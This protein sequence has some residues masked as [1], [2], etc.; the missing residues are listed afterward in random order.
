MYRGECNLSLSLVP[1]YL[2][3][4]PKWHDSLTLSLSYPRQRLY[5]AQ[6]Y[7]KVAELQEGSGDNDDST[8]KIDVKSRI[9]KA[10][11]ALKRAGKKDLYA[12]LGVSQGADQGDIKK[13]YK[14]AALKYVTPPFLPFL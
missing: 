3:F 7:E 8:A 14:K 9:K 1:R 11:V 5:Y 10:K 2:Y 6:D 4:L 12:I 13:A